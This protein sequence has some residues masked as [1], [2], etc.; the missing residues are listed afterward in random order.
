LSAY[1]F[2]RTNLEVLG[3]LANGFV[4]DI[5]EINVLRQIRPTWWAYIATNGCAD[6][7]SNF[8]DDALWN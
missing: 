5:A 3:E 6:R 7:H 8:I 1:Y 4:P 2:A